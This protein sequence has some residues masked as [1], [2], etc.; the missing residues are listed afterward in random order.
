MAR[1]GPTQRQIVDAVMAEL[2][3]S[4]ALAAIVD[5][6]IYVMRAVSPVLV[7]VAD[8]ETP[9][10]D[11]TIG[12][13]T[14]TRNG[15]C[16]STWFETGMEIRFLAAVSCYDDDDES[17]DA[18]EI[19]ELVKTIVYSSQTLMRLVKQWN[20]GQ[21]PALQLR[22]AAPEKGGG[23]IALSLMSLTCTYDVRYSIGA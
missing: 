4:T 21:E 18:I 8:K 12:D 14:S 9:Y 6:R 23:K 3:A 5:T 2:R 11:V 22:T 16:D 15:Y 19:T 1:V 10:L 17:W 20:I 13:T 7:P